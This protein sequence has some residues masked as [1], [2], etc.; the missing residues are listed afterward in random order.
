MKCRTKLPLLLLLTACGN[1]A[2]AL[3]AE[4][5]VIRELDPLTGPSEGVTLVSIRGVG[6]CADLQ[7]DFDGLRSARVDVVSPDLA[8]AETPPHLVGGAEVK[9]S[10]PKDQAIFPERFGYAASKVVLV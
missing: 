1:A 8:F 10:C 3:Y 4:H 6:I 2:D 5:M 7:V 9:L